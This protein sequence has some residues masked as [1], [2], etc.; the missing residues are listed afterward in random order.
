M[1][2]VIVFDLSEVLIRGLVGVEVAL[3]HTL[4]LGHRETLA[5]FGGEHLDR[6]CRGE[7]SEDVYLDAVI[8][9]LPS[10]DKDSLKVAIREN[11]RGPV[12]GTRDLAIELSARHRLVLLSDHGREWV[13]TILQIHPW[14][15][16]WSEKFF[17]FELGL[18]KRQ[19][20]TFFTLVG[21][22]GVPAAQCLLIDDSAVNVQ[23]A[24]QAGWQAIRFINAQQLREEL[25]DRG[26]LLR[27]HGQE[28]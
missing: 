17:S 20:A 1:N 21:M 7:I 8:R 5:L 19:V 22:L 15:A 28:S 9:Q 23:V 18:I 26:L 11:F 27:R 16:E 13:E 2:P 6:Y 3:A 12:T 4:G 25:E 14:L 24:V 10:L